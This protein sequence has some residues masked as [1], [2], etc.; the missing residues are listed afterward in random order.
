[1]QSLQQTITLRWWRGTSCILRSNSCRIIKDSYSNAMRLGKKFLAAIIHVSADQNCIFTTEAHLTSI[2]ICP[3]IRWQ[4]MNSI[5]TLL[6]YLC[7]FNLYLSNFQVLD[8]IF[9]G[10][11]F[12]RAASFFICFHL[13]LVQYYSE[14]T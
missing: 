9:Q 6:S 1:M 8:L 12:L 11:S 2:S 4:M 10:Q 7:R 3:P 14:G 5:L 13:F